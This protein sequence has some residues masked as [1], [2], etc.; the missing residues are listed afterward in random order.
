[1]KTH[2]HISRLHFSHDC[3][4]STVKMRAG[5]IFHMLLLLLVI[6]VRMSSVVFFPSHYENYA[7]LEICSGALVCAAYAMYMLFPFSF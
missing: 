5:L 3:I 4:S 2:R 1:M 6:F 7:S